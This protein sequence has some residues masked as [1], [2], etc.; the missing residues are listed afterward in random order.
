MAVISIYKAVE[1]VQLYVEEQLT[2]VKTSE[3][4]PIP[5]LQGPPGMGKSAILNTLS[6]HLRLKDGRRVR[7]L[8]EHPALR[9]MEYFS[10]L[11]F[12][13]GGDM[14]WS[15]PEMMKFET[16]PEK[17]VLIWFWDDVHLMEPNVAKYL[18]ELFTYRKLHRYALPENTVFVLAGN[19]SKEAGRGKL[20]SPIVNRLGIY[21]VTLTVEEWE[22]SYILKTPITELGVRIIEIDPQPIEPD[23]MVLGFLKRFP[24]FAM[25]KESTMEP[26]GSFRSWTYIGKILS[27]YKKHWGTPT[28]AD[29]KVIAAA[30]VSEQAAAEFTMFAKIYHRYDPSQLLDAKGSKF[31]ETLKQWIEDIEK[32]PTGENLTVAYAQVFQA[33]DYV[34]RNSKLYVLE[35]YY[36]FLEAIT[37]KFSKEIVGLQGLIADALRRIKYANIGILRKLLTI[38]GSPKGTKWLRKFLIQKVGGLD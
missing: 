33:T 31:E 30:H 14:V 23:P 5:Y 22:Q 6:Q 26:F 13:K 4:S 16:D 29:I 15:K 24:E 35:N 17:E 20:F 21:P 38:D 36:R 12:P 3:I 19:S 37:D 1:L 27:R 10:G 7:V 9:P 34:L 18:F 8:A 25:E 32:A 11:P 28:F 2:N